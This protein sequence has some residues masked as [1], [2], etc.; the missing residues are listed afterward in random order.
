MN[1]ELK[2]INAVTTEIKILVPADEAAERWNKHLQK[3]SKKAD[4]PGFRKG[5]APLHLV[6]RMYSMHAME[7]FYNYMVDEY[8]EAAV[9]QEK[10]EYLLFPHVKDISWE[11]GSDME[12]LIEIEHEP[13]LELKQLDHLRVPYEPLTLENEVDN[14]L[15]KLQKEHTRIIDAE[16]AALDDAVDVE[17]TFQI[18][19]QEQVINGTVYAGGELIN[20]SVP[21]LI[22]KKTGDVVQCELSGM[23]LKLSTRNS[24]LALDNDSM[25]PVSI[26]VNA[27]R[28]NLMPDLDDDFAKDLEFDNLEAMKT[29]IAD[30][31]REGNAARDLN[32]KFGAI[33]TKL[34]IDN[35][36]EL[37]TKTIE[38]LAAREAEK[39]PNEAYRQYLDYQYKLQISQDMIRF[40]INK[41]LK[42]QL[43]IKADEQMTEVYI[44]HLAI[45]EDISPEAY[46]EA[47]KD[48][49]S[50]EEFADA[51]DNYAAMMK[52]IETAEFYKAEPEASEEVAEAE[53]VEPE[54][55][56]EA[57]P[58]QEE[59]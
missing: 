15:Q 58:Q 19:G 40:Y 39:E 34:F 27:I 14:Y 52:L 24:G 18:D 49:I 22:G 10:L 7:G 1:V 12:I 47:N 20:R 50:S 55:T 35:K 32:N 3:Y 25:Y 44:Q 46:K 42:R 33:L 13:A 16:E 43:D 37:P 51:A 30:E 6:E 5:K 57:A 17:Y 48:Y 2:A 45:L 26:M 11:K 53:L 8:F 29:K 21:E 41:A 31:L 4:V 28:H 38:Y 36:V 23:T 59:A 56:K 54:A 9:K